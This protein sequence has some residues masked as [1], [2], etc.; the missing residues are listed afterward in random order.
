MRVIAS[1]INE[2][3]RLRLPGNRIVQK[4]RDIPY[5]GDSVVANV[6]YDCE[7]LLI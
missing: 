4:Y 3:E 2:I 7:S 5:L 6:D 1:K